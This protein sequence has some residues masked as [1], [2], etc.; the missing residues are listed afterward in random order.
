MLT[1]GRAAGPV[2]PLVVGFLL[3]AADTPTTIFGVGLAGVAFGG[4][5]FVFAEMRRL[6]GELRRAGAKAQ[7]RITELE[8]EN[9]RLRK[10]MRDDLGG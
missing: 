8:R 1:G 7:E 6:V 10:A 2:A 5:V 4:V 3:T 9:R